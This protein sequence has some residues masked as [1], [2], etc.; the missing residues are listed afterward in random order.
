[1][2]SPN[3][4]MLIGSRVAQPVELNRPSVPHVYMHVSTTWNDMRE[5]I[6]SREHFDESFDHTK[7]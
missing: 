3:S 4:L 1:M 7:S 6:V 2:G 5:R